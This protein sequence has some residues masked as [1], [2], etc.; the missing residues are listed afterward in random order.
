MKELQRKQQQGFIFQGHFQQFCNSVVHE[1]LHVAFVGGYCL[2][3]E[4]SQNFI[5]AKNPDLVLQALALIV[6]QDLRR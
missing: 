4:N 1:L 5:F 3:E 2:T 6:L